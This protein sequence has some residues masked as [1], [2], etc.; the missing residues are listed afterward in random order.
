[1]A[2]KKGFQKRKIEYYQR[3]E[4]NKQDSILAQQIT[5]TGPKVLCAGTI[6]VDDKEYDCIT[7]MYF[8]EDSTALSKFVFPA[9]NEPELTQKQLHKLSKI[10]TARLKKTL[11]HI[12]NVRAKDGRV[13][14][15]Y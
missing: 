3:E 11:D 10:A 12:T 7:W 8:R 6:K 15:Q 14:L 4:F 1:M 9:G 2:Q 5:T 13:L